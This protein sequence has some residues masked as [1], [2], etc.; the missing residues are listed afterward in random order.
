MNF[1]GLG[2][3]GSSCPSVR[4]HS[5]LQ[6]QKNTKK[7]IKIYA[8]PITKNKTTIT[9]IN[10]QTTCKQEFETRRENREMPKMDEEESGTYGS[11]SS[12]SAVLLDDLDCFLFVDTVFFGGWHCFFGGCF[13]FFC[14]V[15]DWLD[16]VLPTGLVDAVMPVLVLGRSLM[17]MTRTH[18]NGT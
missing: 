3:S 17:E 7:C 15:V 8:H 18:D 5:S 1:G 16:L 12:P 14:A 2:A 13:F 10:V 9:T 6:Q 4:N 11:T